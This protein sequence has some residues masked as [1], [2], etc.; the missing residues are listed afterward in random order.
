M[1]HTDGAEMNKL[2]V[3]DTQNLVKFVDEASRHVN[4][5]H[6]KTKGEAA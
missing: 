4:N 6:M 2:L 3:G 5:F 1:I